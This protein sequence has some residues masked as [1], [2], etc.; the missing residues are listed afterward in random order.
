MIED[1]EEEEERIKELTRTIT[2]ELKNALFDLYDRCNQPIVRVLK[3]DYIIDT[4]GKFGDY[5]QILLRGESFSSSH[6]K[7][8]QEAVLRSTKGE[9]GS[10]LAFKV[11][12]DNKEGHQEKLIIEVSLD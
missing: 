3:T 2:K 12:Y 9:F 11:S 6:L 10:D 8:I 5:I 4:T 1:W 7:A